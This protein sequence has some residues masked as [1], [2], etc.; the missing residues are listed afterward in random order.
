MLHITLIASLLLT[1]AAQVA[2]ADN[3]DTESSVAQAAERSQGAD[4]RLLIVNGTSGHVI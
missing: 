2:R 4:H 3:F 1:L